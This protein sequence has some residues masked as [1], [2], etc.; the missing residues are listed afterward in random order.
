[1]TYI[2]GKGI[3]IYRS[4]IITGIYSETFVGHVHGQL[5]QL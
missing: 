4:A 3:K 2:N 5:T 1:M